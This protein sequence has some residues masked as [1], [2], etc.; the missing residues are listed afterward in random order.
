MA[1][2]LLQRGDRL[3]DAAEPELEQPER[4]VQVGAGRLAL[5]AR[6]QRQA[7]SH[8]PPADVLGAHRGLDVGERGEA[9]REQRQLPG[10][11]RE[12]DRLG[13]LGAGG[14]PAAE[15]EVQVRARGERVDQRAHRAG[16]ARGGD[17]AVEDPLRAVELLD[18]DGGVRGHAHDLDDRQRIALE[19]VRLAGTHQRVALLDVAERQVRLADH[20]GRQQL[21]RRVGGR[22]ERAGALGGGDERVHVAGDHVRD[23]SL[24]EHAGARR[25]SRE[26]TR[27]ASATSSS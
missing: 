19:Q 4:G 11:V 24:Q 26:R 6:S 1:L 12:L 5:E 17:Q 16:V 21:D 22:G 9:V 13:R 27:S 8:V 25:G 2:G 14:G 18:P 15:P 3:G 20:R 23:R 7:L 10:V